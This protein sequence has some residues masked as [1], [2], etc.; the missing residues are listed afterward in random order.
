MALIESA[1][2]VWDPLI[3]AVAVTI[4]VAFVLVIRSFGKSGFKN[5]GD[6]TKP[7]FSGDVVPESPIKAGNLYWGFFESLK[8]YYAFLERLHS[9]L[10]NDY[11]YLFVLAIVVLLIAVFAGELVWA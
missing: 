11:V 10:V 2:G 1:A 7:F 9:G 4:I 8:G 5:R 3:W 6:K